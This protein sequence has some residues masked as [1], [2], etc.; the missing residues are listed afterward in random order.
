[1]VHCKWINTNMLFPTYWLC[2]YL[3]NTLHFQASLPKNLTKLNV[4]VNFFLAFSPFFNLVFPFWLDIPTFCH[5]KFCIKRFLLQ[6]RVTEVHRSLWTLCHDVFKNKFSKH[7][8]CT[9]PAMVLKEKSS[10]LLRQ[11]PGNESILYAIRSALWM[12]CIKTV[13]T[14]WIIS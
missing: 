13:N 14:T 11:L 6:Q 12:N 5:V 3:V 8:L 2:I 10:N 9:D 1:M 4:E 7:L